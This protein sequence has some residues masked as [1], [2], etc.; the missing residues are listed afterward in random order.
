MR[1][2]LTPHEIAQEARRVLPHLAQAGRV[3]A[4]AEGGGYGLFDARNFRRRTDLHVSAREIDGLLSAELILCREKCED[5]PRPTHYVMSEVGRAYLMRFLNPNAPFS[6]QHRFL[7]PG[8]GAAGPIA[9]R[10][11]P[12]G[13]AA[14]PISGRSAPGGGAAS[15]ISGRS[16][17]GAPSF[18]SH[19]FV[20]RRETPLGWLATRKT[21]AGDAFLSEAEVAAGERLR[22]D[23]TR[24]LLTP[25]TTVN[26]PQER[27][28]TSRRLDYSPTELSEAAE[29]AKARFW[30]AVD[31]VGPELSPVLVAVACHLKS[32]ETVEADLKLPARSA[33]S[34]LKAG[35]R[36]LTRHYGLVPRCRARTQLK[37]ECLEPL[38]DI[39]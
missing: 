1:V 22:E 35:L 25:R 36:T 18:S 5:D 24:A 27:V 3:L 32:L 4:G 8:G 34:L 6:A 19:L 39:L 20:N 26:W 33:K 15:P 12:G 16:A 30:R 11:A 9:G 7:A 21:A 10:S 2:K 23:F 28:D 29:A 13:G 37:K 17:P 14:S 31:V 38:P